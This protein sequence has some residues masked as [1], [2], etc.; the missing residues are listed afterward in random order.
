[1]KLR[2]VRIK[3]FRGIPSLNV[4]IGDFTVLVGENNSGK[5]AIIEAIESA[6]GRIARGSESPF[7]RLDYHVT[8][9]QTSPEASPGIEIELWFREDSPKEWPPAIHQDL[10]AAIQ[11]DPETNLW[12]VGVRVTSKWDDVAK[13]FTFD[14]ELLTLSGAPLPPG[15]QAWEALR[16]LFR[17]VRLFPIPTLRNASE[18]FSPRSRA[19]GRFLAGLNIPDA[20][21]APLK[22]T[23]AQLNGAL[24]GVDP[25]LEKLRVGLEGVPKVI[26][27]DSG[28]KTT[29]ELV[30]LE[31][32]DLI[33]KAELKIQNQTSE[34]PLPL[35]SHGQGIQ[36]LAV[37]YLYNT[38]AAVLRRDFLPETTTILTVEEPEAHLHP[39]AA[40]VVS[41]E[42]R[43]FAGQVIATTHSP[44]FVMEVPFVDLRMLRL[45]STG[46]RLYRVRKELRVALH[47]TTQLSALV[48][49]NSSRFRYEASPPTLVVTGY[50]TEAELEGLKKVYARNEM[51]VRELSRLEGDLPTLVSAADLTR[52][53]TYVKRIRGEA[54]FARGW[55]LCE[56]QSDHVYLRYFS[57]VA[58]LDLDREGISLIDFK[59]NG[60]LGAFASL[61]RGLDIP[62]IALV[63]NDSGFASAAQE[64]YARGFSATEQAQLMTT[65]P[66]DGECIELHLMRNGFAEAFELMLTERG[67]APTFTRT[68][69]RWPASA[70]DQVRADKVAFATGF[71]DAVRRSTAPSPPIPST[72]RAF[73]DEARRRV[74]SLG[75]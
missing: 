39:Q 24:A 70:M 60:S 57:E 59:N 40:R 29:I 3:N 21:W 17:Y 71:A 14:Q 41:S 65:F 28:A 6:W 22:A 35:D 56:G 45:S 11:L 48:S 12:S 25:S 51:A 64:L 23:I 5:T 8:S 16:R 72:I 7:E 34:V 9:S 4:P 15:R 27:T 31:P 50:P 30:S 54:L 10:S 1:M 73:L 68:D 53:E 18:R 63:D 19:W 36:S 49:A 62:A 13:E 42:M 52:L 37:I 26:S 74:R 75:R 58:G 67:N 33:S 44:H 46:K 2:E 66:M 69:A 47:P 38:H 20:Q 32:S 61:A 43:G 55:L